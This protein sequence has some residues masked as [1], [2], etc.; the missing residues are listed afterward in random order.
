MRGPRSSSRYRQP[1][2]TGLSGDNR[3]LTT[4][5]AAKAFNLCA[6]PGQLHYLPLRGFLTFD[7]ES[8]QYLCAALLQHGK[9]VASEGTV[10]SVRRSS[11]RSVSQTPPGRSTRSSASSA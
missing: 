6:E 1:A 2:V 9:A 10:V 5:A 7:R 4:P 3:A 8:E 11:R